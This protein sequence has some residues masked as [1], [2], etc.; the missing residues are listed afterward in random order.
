MIIWLWQT[1]LRSDREWEINKHE[2]GVN[3]V[4][5]VSYIWLCAPKLIHRLMLV[6]TEPLSLQDVPTEGATRQNDTHTH[7]HSHTHTHAHTHTAKYYFCGWLS[8][9]AWY[10]RTQ[11]N[12][13]SRK[14]AFPF[15][16]KVAG[17]LQL[18]LAHSNT[19]AL[20]VRSSPLD[21]RSH[22]SPRKAC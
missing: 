11:I 15:N 17:D 12:T 1:R 16:I 5:S 6:T 7:T 19:G 22:S 18:L 20:D 2:S 8:M 14:R 9:L 4:Y 10:W 3:R 13:L 21:D